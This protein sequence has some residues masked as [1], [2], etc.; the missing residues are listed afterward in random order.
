MKY[1]KMVAG[2][3]GALVTVI[4]GAYAVDQHYAKVRDVAELGRDYRQHVVEGQLYDT[5]KQIWQ[6]E[7]RLKVRPDDNTAAERLRQL[8]WEKQ[9]LERQQIELKKGGS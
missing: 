3:I 1:L 8:E 2:C 6:Y 5:Q 9:R 4:G 7:D